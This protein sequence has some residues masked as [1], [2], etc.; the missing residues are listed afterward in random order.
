LVNSPIY[1]I[2]E[3]PLSLYQISNR[4][5]NGFGQKASYGSKLHLKKK[6]RIKWHFEIKNFKMYCGLKLFSFCQSQTAF[7]LWADWIGETSRILMLSMLATLITSWTLQL[8]GVSWENHC[9]FKDLHLVYVHTKKI[10]LL[11]AEC[12]KSLNKTSVLIS[13]SL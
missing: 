3:N 11:L 10:L 2:K 13:L 7:L 12:A 6:Y 4:Q 1:S 9:L 5:L 8:K